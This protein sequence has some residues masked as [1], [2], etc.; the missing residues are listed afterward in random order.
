MTRRQPPVPIF[1]L[2]TVVAAAG[3]TA[4]ASDA[5]SEPHTAAASPIDA[6]RYLVTVAGCNDCHTDGY[7]FSGG[8]VPEAQ[9][10]LGSSMGWRGPWGT[11][12]ARNLRITVT[13]MTEDE[14]VQMLKT[15][16]SLLPMPWMN[17][18]QMAEA[19]MR[20]IYQ[21]FRSLGPAGEQPPSPVPPD[22]EPT[23]PYLSLAPVAPMVQ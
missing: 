9:W 21:Y 11:S 23:T 18:N 3:C 8:N 22:Q 10:F 17:V 15:R 12:Y 14:W 16:T 2:L 7:L 20:A 5:P 4:S 13:T 19:D 1:A 6:G